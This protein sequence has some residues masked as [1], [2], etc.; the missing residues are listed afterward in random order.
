M[1]PIRPVPRNQVL[2][3]DDVSLLRAVNL[4]AVAQ[5]RTTG[6]PSS[7]NARNFGSRPTIRLRPIA[8]CNPRSQDPLQPGSRSVGCQD[9]P[10]SPAEGQEAN[11]SRPSPRTRPARRARSQVL[12]DCQRC[13]PRPGVL[14][15]VSGGDS[16]PIPSCRCRGGEGPAPPLQWWW[17]LGG[18]AWFHGGMV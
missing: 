11:G 10:R 14:G 18:D 3:P 9:E 15:D 13:P 12:S 5:P 4:D 1:S 6:N 8:W 17:V 16:G 7:R 2:L